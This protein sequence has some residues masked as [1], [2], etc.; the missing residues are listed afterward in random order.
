MCLCMI[1]IITHSRGYNYAYYTKVKIFYTN[2]NSF[3]HNSLNAYFNNSFDRC[4]TTFIVTI[5]K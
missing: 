3:F 2:I 1:G 5:N 4:F